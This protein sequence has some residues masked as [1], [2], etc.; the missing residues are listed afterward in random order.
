MII[1]SF[2]GLK[3]NILFLVVAQLVEQLYLTSEVRISNPAKFIYSQL[4]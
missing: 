1:L 3:V 2:K 4:N